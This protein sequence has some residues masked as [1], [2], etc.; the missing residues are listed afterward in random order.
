MVVDAGY[1]SAMHSDAQHGRGAARLERL[2]AGAREKVAALAPRGGDFEDRHYFVNAGGDEWTLLMAE[3]LRETGG[4]RIPLRYAKAIAHVLDTIPVAILDGELLVGEVGVG[5]PGQDRRAEL[6]AAQQYLDQIEECA[7]D[8][9]HAAEDAGIQE[10]SPAN[11]LWQDLPDDWLPSQGFS[12]VGLWGL[13]RDWRGRSGHLIL[14]YDAVM[15][16]GLGGLLAEVRGL[17]AKAADERARQFYRA[18][19]LVLEAASR[20]VGR[21]AALA[22]SQAAGTEDPLRK[23][24]LAQIAAIC[25]RI[26]TEP[27]RTFR[28][29]IQLARFVHLLGKLDDGALGHGLGRIDQ[30][31]Y[32]FYLGDLRAGRITPEE[33]QELIIILWIKL[34][35]QAEESTAVVIGGTSRDGADATNDLSYMFLKATAMV[36]LKQPN[37][38]VRIHRNSP[39]QFVRKVA[40]TM[41]LGIGNPGIFNDDVLVPAFEAYGVPTDEARGYGIEGCVQTFL[42]GRQVPWTHGHVNLAKCLELALND[43]RCRLTGRQLGPHTGDPLTF[44]EFDDLWCALGRQVQACVDGLLSAKDYYDAVIPKVRSSP[45]ISALTQDCLTRGRDVYEGGARYYFT[46]VYGVG[47]GSTADSMAAIEK[48]VFE[49]KRVQMAQLLAALDTDFAGQE[50][51]R[52]ILLQRAPKYGND[53]EY[54]DGL[55]IQIIDCFTRAVKSHRQRSDSSACKGYLALVGSVSAHV[56]LGKMTAAM[57][58]GRRAGEPLSDGGSPSQGRDTCG[59]VANL[60]SVSKPDFTQVAGGAAI[61]LKF[62]PSAI[63]G[64][65][66]TA[67]LAG[68]IRAYFGCGGEQLQINAVNRQTLED[69]VAHP[70]D[71]RDLVVRVAGFTAYF[72]TLEPKMQAEII[73]RTASEFA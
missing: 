30:Y 16:K 10:R 73:A 8:A 72:V 71:H 54:V 19:A 45:L 20:Y 24:E 18:V 65:R 13:A 11:T 12:E 67:N 61:N 3:S 34:N 28:E 41:S 52:Q 39:E 6:A 60:R 64:E 57:P 68:A 66:G 23:E 5:W 36:R 15:A 27:P 31:L 38:S 35:R 21:Y 4:E 47:L 33:A 58:D 53:D 25:E 70:E 63:Q 40:E 9:G 32:P 7:L 50:S 42:C 37:L 22:Q 49:E 26:T 44:T 55:A 51:F 43:G 2:L 69:A 62:F 46:G 29:A 56:G 17:T 1:A 59:P 48:L 14:D